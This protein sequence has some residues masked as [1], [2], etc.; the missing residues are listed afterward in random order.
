MGSAGLGCEYRVRASV[1]TRD[2]GGGV[3]G[4]VEFSLDGGLLW[5]PAEVVVVGGGGGQGGQGGAPPVVVGA[6]S[7]CL[8]ELLQEEDDDGGDGEGRGGGGGGMGSGS[9]EMEW[10]VD[11]GSAPY[12]CFTDGQD[13]VAV[14]GEIIVRAVDDSLNLGRP[15]APRRLMAAM[16]DEECAVEE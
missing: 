13:P 7:A 5:H 11:F 2:V 8:H 3:V 6:G 14:P 10:L 9:G 16:E 15:S 1:A 4:G 12:D